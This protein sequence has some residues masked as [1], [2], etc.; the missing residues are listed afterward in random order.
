MPAEFV[1]LENICKNLQRYDFDGIAVFRGKEE[2]FR[3]YATEGESSE[4]LIDAFESW[5]NDMLASNANNFQTYKIQLYE[6]PE[7]AKKRRGTVSFSFQ[8]VPTPSTNPF[9]KKSDNNQVSGDMV[10]KDTM[11]ALIENERLKNQLY[12]LESR[13]S[14]I[15]NQNDD[16]DDDDLQNNVGMIGAIEDAVKDKL[17]QLIDLAIGFFTPKKEPMTMSLGANI[18]EILAEFRQ[19]NPS[20][21]SD[22]HKLLNLAKTKPDLF[23]ILILQLRAM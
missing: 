5:A 23:K 18:D 21:D 13:L 9:V 22:L 1:G 20:I 14:E 15:E 4:N 3:R 10:H 11:L 12:Q 8:L 2:P 17:P 16:D 6:F 7:E 19:I